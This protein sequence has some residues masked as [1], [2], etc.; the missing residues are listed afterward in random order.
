MDFL[1]PMFI[2]N[3]PFKPMKGRDEIRYDEF[4]ECTEH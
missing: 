3:L 2:H 1:R 4:Q